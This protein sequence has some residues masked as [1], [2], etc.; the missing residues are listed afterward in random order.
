MPQDARLLRLCEA[1][2]INPE[3]TFTLDDWTEQ[4][5][6]SRRTLARLFR[7][8]CGIAFTTWRQRVRFYAAIEAL[9]RGASVAEA[10]RQSGYSSP[11]AFTSAFRKSFGVAPRNLS[12]SA[13]SKHEGNVAVLG[14]RPNDTDAFAGWRGGRRDLAKPKARDMRSR[15]IP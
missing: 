15:R 1:L 10:A 5:G 14:L 13:R 3:L 2:I 4:V 11:S 7:K 9:S 8:D 12:K 6:A